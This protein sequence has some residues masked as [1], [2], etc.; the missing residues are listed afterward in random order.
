[1]R[2]E[3]RT[4]DSEHMCAPLETSLGRMPSIPPLVA[5]HAFVPPL[6]TCHTFLTLSV[7]ATCQVLIIGFPKEVSSQPAYRKAIG[8]AHGWITAAHKDG[9]R[10]L[11]RRHRKLVADERRKQ[12]ELWNRRLAADKTVDSMAK[13]KAFAKIGFVHGGCVHML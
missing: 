10:R 2:Y 3:K 12:L 6:A 9:R 1:M 8:V 13:N 7:G 11:M 4:R 5:W